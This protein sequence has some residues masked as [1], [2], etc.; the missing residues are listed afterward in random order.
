[1]SRKETKAD[2]VKL[3]NEISVIIL[4][5]ADGKNDHVLLRTRYAIADALIDHGWRP[6]NWP[7]VP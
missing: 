3:S 7:Y 1:M 5:A 4:E 2:L 6:T